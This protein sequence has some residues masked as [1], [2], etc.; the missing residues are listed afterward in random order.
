MIDIYDTNLFDL[1]MAVFD[2]EATGRTPAKDAVIQ[3]AVVKITEGRIEEEGWTSLVNPGPAFLPLSEFII[4]F[5]G[6]ETEML[7]SAPDMA[8]VLRTFDA[9]VGRRIVAG[10]NIQSYDIPILRKH[11]RE[12]GVEPQLDFYFDTLMVARKL[13]PAP[14]KLADIAAHYRIDIDPDQQHNALYDAR[15]AARIVLAQIDELAG[16]GVTTFG[17]LLDFI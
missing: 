8:T 15:I 1:E 9:R 12:E 11:A 6:I 14:R 16:K 13:M 17:D 10:Q 4:G 2:V 5:T 7:E 3:I